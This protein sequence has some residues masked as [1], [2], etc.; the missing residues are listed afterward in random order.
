MN[1]RQLLYPSTH[2]AN[3]CII[4]VAAEGQKRKID[5]AVAQRAYQIFQ[6]RGGTGWHELEDW[7]KAEAEVR[8]KVCTGI[9]T[10]DHTVFI[11][12]DAAGFEP[13]KIEVWVLPRLLT[14]SG[15]NRARGPQSLATSPNMWR[16]LFPTC[17]AAGT[18]FILANA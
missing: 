9:T 5:A 12:T 2:E 13:G 17:L 16:G 10:Q 15:R 6:K 1:T 14:I 8:C 3:V 4:P 7:R 18:P 11:G